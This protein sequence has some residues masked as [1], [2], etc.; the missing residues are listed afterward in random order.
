MEILDVFPEN[1][2]AFGLNEN[3]HGHSDISSELKPIPDKQRLRLTTVGAECPSSEARIAS[4][5]LLG[6]QNLIERGN[7]NSDI[8]G[9]IYPKANEDI[10]HLRPSNIVAENMEEKSLVS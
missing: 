1:I 10:P 3:K 5:E 4:R 6:K 7:G 9:A 2:E 8:V